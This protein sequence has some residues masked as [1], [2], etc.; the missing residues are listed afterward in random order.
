MFCNEDLFLKTKKFYL[1]VTYINTLKIPPHK[2]MLQFTYFFK[3][4]ISNYMMLYFHMCQHQIYTTKSSF[5]FLFHKIIIFSNRILEFIHILYLLAQTHM[6]L[7]R[8]QNV[9]SALH[10]CFSIM[11]KSQRE[12]LIEHRFLVATPK[13]LIQLLWVG[14]REFVLFSNNIV[15]LTLP[16]SGITF[17]DNIL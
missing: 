11:H 4:T 6:V 13:I 16:A 2:L 15:V 10:H 1:N 7:Q 17:S 14:T 5:I 12:K 3:K 8:T 9:P